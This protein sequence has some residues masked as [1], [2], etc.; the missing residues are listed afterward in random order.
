MIPD[1]AVEAALT[2]LGEAYGDDAYCKERQY[3]LTAL[4]AASQHIAAQALKYA[5]HSME[6]M[7]PLLRAQYVETLRLYAAEPWRLVPAEI[8]DIK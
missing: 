6:I 8:G 4:E 3:V 5:A 7:P 2:A 1:E